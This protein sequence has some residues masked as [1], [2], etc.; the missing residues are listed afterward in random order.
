MGAVLQVLERLAKAMR[1][2]EIANFMMNADARQFP[3]RRMS[4][5]VPAPDAADHKHHSFSGRRICSNDGSWRRR[6]R[7]D[8]DHEDHTG[9]SSDHESA[10]ISRLWEVL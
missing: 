10:F 8:D 9:I 6:R 5:D 7:R 3:L 4:E 1:P 2:G